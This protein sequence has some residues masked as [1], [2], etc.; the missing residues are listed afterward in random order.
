MPVLPVLCV[1]WNEKIKS[2]KL[3]KIFSNNFSTKIFMIFTLFT[4]I[5][6]SSFTGFFILHQKWTLTNELVRRGKLTA[7]LLAYNSRLGVFAENK[8]L[9]Q[10]LAEGFLQ[11]EEVIALSIFTSEGNLLISR[12]KQ[13]KS[14]EVDKGKLKLILEKIGAYK[15]FVYLENTADTIE[16]WSP[17]I[18][19]RIILSME[20]LFLIESFF[21]KTVR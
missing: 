15:S 4:L 7:E 17:I 19:S 20:T 10:N 5:I 6:S 18:S 1:L 8:K 21:G 3:L 12:Q 2:M 11:R 16:I 13:G 9:L 14:V